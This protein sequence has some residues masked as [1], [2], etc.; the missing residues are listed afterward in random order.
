VCI[1]RSP[2]SVTSF[3]APRPAAL[4]TDSLDSGAAA[5]ARMIRALPPAYVLGGY[6]AGLA[7]IRSLG[8]RGVPTVA[9]TSSPHEH[10]RRSR[11]ARVSVAAPDPFVSEADY[12]ATIAGLA[13]T[14]GEGILFPTT[15]ESLA[16]IASRRDEL[17]ARH[18]LACPSPET[19][20]HV[21]DK[22]FTYASAS[23]AGVAVP[24]S[25]FPA[26]ELELEHVLDEVAFPC[27]V[28]PR[29]SHRYQRAFGLKV[30]VASGWE[31]ALTAWR[32]A[33]AAG[34]E[35]II[36]EIVPGP[37]TGGVNY[38]ALFRNGEPVA[39]LT[40]RKLRL[41]PRDFGYPSAVISAA[42]PEVV[43]S[44]RKTLRAL[45]LDGYA[46]VEFKRDA[47]D[48]A[49][50][51]LEVNGRP[52]MSGALSVRCGVDFPWLTYRSLV[53][54]A[55][56]PEVLSAE[57]GVYWVNEASDPLALLSRRRGGERS[58]RGA[59][60]PYLRPHVFA[61]LSASDPMPFAA[62]AGLLR[63]GSRRREELPA[64][65]SREPLAAGS[66]I[67]R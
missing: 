34:I 11:Y 20:R 13:E 53:D 16:A 66:R 26:D 33:R 39:E 42:V 9:V 40:A 52:N 60:G 58:L 62:R 23:A 44:G 27:L 17:R 1:A 51:L 18:R 38:N 36:Q 65:L 22:R 25:A 3:A 10:A 61:W 7:V 35:T 24:Q 57:Q 21:V 43:E 32:R 59:L 55:A 56:V 12:V 64:S 37:E 29:E 19:I 41:M 15:D 5:R 67:S 47:R 6:E 63:S 46:N 14:I 48:G 4:D 28:K 54:P 31:E 45:E 50:R 8:R 2:A 30:T 49:Y